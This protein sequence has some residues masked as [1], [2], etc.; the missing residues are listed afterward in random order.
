MV[1]DVVTDLGQI[2]GDCVVFYGLRKQFIDAANTCWDYISSL[3][4]SHV[5]IVVL[6]VLSRISS[7]RHSLSPLLT[8]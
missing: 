1:L 2:T 4:R 7:G 8:P 6:R 5:M 3:L